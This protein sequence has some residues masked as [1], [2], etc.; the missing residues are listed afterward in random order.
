GEHPLRRI[1]RAGPVEGVR[2]QAGAPAL[3]P[4][5]APAPHVD[6]GDVGAGEKG[7][8]RSGIAEGIRLPGGARLDTEGARDPVLA[9]LEVA[10]LYSRGDQTGLGLRDAGPGE[11][12]LMVMHKGGEVSSLLRVRLPEMPGKQQL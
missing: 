3:L 5:A 11:G 12:E 8:E 7:W 6:I 1:G 4:K 2:K 10:D 9:E